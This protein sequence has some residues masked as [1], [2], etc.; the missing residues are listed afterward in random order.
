MDLRMIY[1]KSTIK[2]NHM[3]YDYKESQVRDTNKTISDT[4]EDEVQKVSLVRFII[5]FFIFLYHRGI[6]PL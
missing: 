6:K 5:N 3:K 2:I 1:I 4:A